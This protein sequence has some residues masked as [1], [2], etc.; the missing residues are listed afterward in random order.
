M[1][2]LSIFYDSQYALMLINDALLLF[3]FINW[4]VEKYQV[5]VQELLSKDQWNFL[6]P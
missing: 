4:K 6:I 5:E 1:I 3:T 2:R